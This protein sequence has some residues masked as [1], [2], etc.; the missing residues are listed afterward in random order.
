MEPRASMYR[1]SR[2]LSSEGGA[3]RSFVDA[4]SVLLLTWNTGFYR[5]CAF[6]V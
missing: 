3:T 5:Y 2:F 6:D 4:L 1:V